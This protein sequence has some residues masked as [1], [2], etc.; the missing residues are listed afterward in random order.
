M[1]F[2]SGFMTCLNSRHWTPMKVSKP[3]KHIYITLPTVQCFIDSKALYCATRR[4]VSILMT[5]PC[6]ERVFR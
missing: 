3:I 4:I 1:I 5:F 2:G 6:T